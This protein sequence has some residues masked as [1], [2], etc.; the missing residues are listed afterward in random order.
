[1]TTASQQS[2]FTTPGENDFLHFW[3]DVFL[4]RFGIAVRIQ[5]SAETRV[6]CLGRKW[7]VFPVIRAGCKATDFHFMLSEYARL[8]QASNYF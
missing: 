8:V 3:S 2:A 5:N 1:M 4:F 6:D 7:V